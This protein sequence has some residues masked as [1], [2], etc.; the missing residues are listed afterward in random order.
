MSKITPCLW[1]D[2]DAE[3]AATFYV[4]LVPDSR[5]DRVWSSP[6]DY[7]GGKAGDALLVEFT[8]AGQTFQALNGRTKGEYSHALSLSID[9]EDQPEVDRVWGKILENGGREEQ[10]GWIRDRWNVPWQI[11]PRALAEM[12]RS[13]DTAARARAFGAMMEMVKLD[14]AKLQAAFEG[15]AAA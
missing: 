9:C 2:S 14:V 11:V 7:P 8:L 6:G 1:Y 12:M 15:K 13:S 10:C 4:G 5:I 3:E